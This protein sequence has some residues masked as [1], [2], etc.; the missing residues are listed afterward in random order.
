MKTER[1][2]ETEKG[3]KM[4]TYTERERERVGGGREGAVGLPRFI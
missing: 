4:H 3:R 1:K 2:R